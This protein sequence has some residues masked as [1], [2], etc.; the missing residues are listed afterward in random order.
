MIEARRRLRRARPSAIAL[1]VAL[2]LSLA[3]YVWVRSFDPRPYVAWVLASGPLAMPGA[4]AALML[5]ATLR[6]GDPYRRD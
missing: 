6:Y 4:P 3:A 1:G 2:L 5:Y